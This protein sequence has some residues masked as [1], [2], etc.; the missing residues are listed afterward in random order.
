V[1]GWKKRDAIDEMVNGGFGFH[2]MWDNLVKFL[3]GLDI[4]A[5]KKKAGIAAVQA[6]GNSR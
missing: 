1:C 2:P 6:T 5:L 3:N 4:E